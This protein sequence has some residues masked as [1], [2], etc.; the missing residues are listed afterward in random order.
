MADG[1]YEVVARGDRQANQ[2]DGDLCNF[3][4]TVLRDWRTFDKH[5][6]EERY[7]F[8]CVFECVLARPTLRPQAWEGRT[9]DDPSVVALLQD[10]GEAL[11]RHALILRHNAVRQ[12]AEAKL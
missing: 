12:R 8:A 4:G 11:C 1:A 10:H 2:L 3:A 5:F 9:A 6:D 7:C